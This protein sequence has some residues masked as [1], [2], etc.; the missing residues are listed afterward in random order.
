[1]KQKK[2]SKVKNEMEELFSIIANYDRGIVGLLLLNISGLLWLHFKE[3]IKRLEKV[4]RYTEEH[5]KAHVGLAKDCS[6][7][8]EYKG[9]ERR[10]R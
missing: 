4:E 3:H 7:R 2:W 6:D 1:M 5:N 10:R 8:H 9:I